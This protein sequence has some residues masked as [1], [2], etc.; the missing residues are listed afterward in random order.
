MKLIIDTSDKNTVKLG[1]FDAQK[2]IEH[3]FAV[4]FDQA[5]KL[6][7]AVRSFLRQE[8]VELTDVEEIVV[9]NEG[10]S[11]TSLRIGVAT[12]NAL[13]F[14]LGIPVKAQNREDSGKY[15]FPKYDR[16]PNITVQK[17]AIQNTD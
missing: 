5:E 4:Q 8:K 15:I 10:D 13:A 3:S 12:A 6:L 16:E 1:L 11:F 17:T 9:N 2:L 14:G 7:P